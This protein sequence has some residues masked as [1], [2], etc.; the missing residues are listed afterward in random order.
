MPDRENNRHLNLKAGDWVEVR[1]RQEIQVTLDQNGRL[2]NLPFMPEM[3]QYCGKR[4][5]VSKRADKTCQYIVGWSIRRVTDCVHLELVRCDGTGHGGCE[6]A[7]LIFWFFFCKQKTAYD[8][9]SP[10]D[11]R[12]RGP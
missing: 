1:S 4:L 10:E 5:R 7:C 6:A 2:E 8:I 9:L 3:L 12:K 11:L